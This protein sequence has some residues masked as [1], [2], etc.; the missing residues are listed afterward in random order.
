[1]Y[2]P[3]V[4]KKYRTSDDDFSSEHKRINMFSPTSKRFSKTNA[5]TARKRYNGGERNKIHVK[6]AGPR[7]DA[8]SVGKRNAGK[9]SDAQRVAADTTTAAERSSPYEDVSVIQDQMYKRGNV[10]FTEVTVNTITVIIQECNTD[11]GFFKFSTGPDINI[12]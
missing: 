5:P 1:M 9:P 2:F 8:S 10:T 12:K 4:L 6:A 11:K 3:V 7:D